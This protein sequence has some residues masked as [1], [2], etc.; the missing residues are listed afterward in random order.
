MAP[1][2]NKEG[3]GRGSQNAGTELDDEDHGSAALPGVSR[4]EATEV[5]RLDETAR[6]LTS[7]KNPGFDVFLSHHHADA[8]L[9]QQIAERLRDRGINPWLD[10]FNLTPGREWQ[11]EIVEGLRAAASCAVFIGPFGL[12]DWARQELAIAQD[13]AARERDF[14]LFLVL[15]PE[16]PKLDDSSLAFVVTRTW[17]DL[18]N[19][20][21]DSE[22]FDT[23]VRAIT[24]TPGPAP[25][26][27]HGPDDVCPYRGLEVFEEEHAA[28]FFGRDDDVKRI[29]E[30]LKDTRFLAVIGASGDGK[31]SVVR[32]GVIPAVRS[33]SLRGSETWTVCVI[34]PGARPLNT[35]AARLAHL[36]PG[37]SMQ[38]T[39][40]GMLADERSLDLSVSLGFDDHPADDRLLLVVDQ[41]EEVF[42]LCADDAECSAFLANLCYAATI[43]G[44][45]VVILLA[46]RAD[47]YQHCTAHPQLRA[48]MAS[49][50]F[51]VGPLGR[52]ALRDVVEQPA[53]CAHLRL[54]PGLAEMILG[55]VTDRPGTLPL[56]EYVLLEVW[57]RRQADLLTIDAYVAS[58]RVDQALAHRADAVYDELGPAR[59]ELT[60]RV[61]LRL[62]QPSDNTEDTRRQ[63]EFGELLTRPEEQEDL[64]AVVRALADARLLT[65]GSDDVTGVPVVDVVH[66][67]LIRAWPRLRA[68]IDESREQLR[69][70][71][72]LSEAAREWD[73]N[74]RDDGFLYRGSRLAAWQ[75][76][77]TEAMNEIE[78]SFLTASREREAHDRAIRR[79]Q[80]GTVMI[81]LAATVVVVGALA[82]FALSQR[83]L[84]RSREI[85]ATAR[86]QLGID[87]ELSLLLAR[88]AYSIKRT[89]EAEAVLRQAILDSRA[90]VT[91]QG[92]HTEAIWS[93]D[94]SPDGSE[95]VSASDDKRVVIRKADGT[96]KPVV[97]QGS[98]DGVNGAVFGPDGQLVAAGD[99]KGTV[100]IWDRSK[101]NQRTELPAHTEPIYGLAF[102]PDGQRLA[103]TGADGLLRITSIAEG[104]ERPSRI[105]KTGTSTAWSLA[106]SPD[107]RWLVAG[108]N[109]GAIMVWDGLE[110]GQPRVLRE[111]VGPVYGL[112]FSSDGAE[113]A[114]A[115]MDATVRVWDVA[116]WTVRYVLE[117]HHG[118]VI[119]VAWSPDGR[120]ATGSEDST[121][122]IWR[123]GTAGEPTVLRG[124]HGGV[125]TV[126]FS[127]R[128]DQIASGGYDGNIRIWSAAREDDPIVVHAHE[129]AIVSLAL[130]PDGK[131]LATGGDDGKVR[132]W[133][134]LDLQEQPVEFPH[135]TEIRDVSFS[136]D[137]R[138]LA[139]AAFDKKVRL[140]DLSKPQD[141]PLELPHPSPVYAVSFSPDGRFL[142][143]GDFNGIVRLWPSDGKGNPKE[144]TKAGLP[145]QRLSFSPDGRSLASA[146]SDR[147]VL[148]WNLDRA[149]IPGRRLAKW[150][151]HVYDVSFSRDSRL[152]ATAGG[153][154]TVRVMSL[155]GQPHAMEFHGH[156]GAARGVSFS[157]DGRR[158]AS[159]G[160]DRTVALWEL[161]KATN[162][163]VLGQHDRRAWRVAF[164]PS[165]KELVSA[166]E[167]GTISLW[168]CPVCGSTEE[169]VSLAGKQVTREL[170]SEERRIFL[171]D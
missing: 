72:R 103:S 105:L 142:A 154:E 32:A 46:M 91:L 158:V 104:A 36:F 10:R 116:T 109:E 7:Q 126:A 44:G 113:L 171:H 100:Q 139:T 84:A 65:T 167:D 62:V 163:V 146:G 60:R 112:D 159:A 78:R 127:P 22:G 1:V 128:G 21:N 99:K 96:G 150:G 155:H 117:G 135:P 66:E 64:E 149:R 93:V 30:K 137:G 2:H 26:E 134:L 68:W 39:L 74:D 102:S 168:K 132:L 97:L 63:A 89:P 122:R 14:R 47:F 101:G 118:M 54:E 55:D 28:F 141:H 12:G 166:S 165:G 59:Q 20:I 114:S 77:S 16:A 49:H 140:W 57:Q 157:P 145:I 120:L 138:R 121:L 33:G 69:A 87:P 9:V 24:R 23:L 48:L 95:V 61:L 152:L 169:M 76:E 82:L 153:D 11:P 56:L 43:P 115:G 90:R 58:G 86:N 15:L 143:T 156:Q 53:A 131:R 67:S 31:S 45:R 136:Y 51:V 41:F 98:P 110:P 19:G 92:D 52:D 40:D 83:Q 85:A 3:D 29:L 27:T 35:L 75:D 17:V 108:G 133:N 107:G 50:Q 42:S 106:F 18:R 170:S 5:V 94:F 160:S 34:T 6:P 13:R 161:P 4:A 125:T 129:G 88:E 164:L 8:P 144:L 73:Y 162:P 130:S 111:H 80:L 38:H 148:L 79:R 37:E 81:S 124:H 25:S 71:R 123:P 147:T 70:Q 119:G 151:G